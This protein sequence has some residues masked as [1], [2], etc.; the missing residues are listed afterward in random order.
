MSRFLASCCRFFVQGHTSFFRCSSCPSNLRGVLH[1]WRPFATLLTYGVCSVISNRSMFFVQSP[2]RA[3]RDEMRR[4]LLY[5]TL[6]YVVLHAATVATHRCGSSASDPSSGMVSASATLSKV[7]VYGQCCSPTIDRTVC[8]PLAPT[9]IVCGTAGSTR[10][11][12]PPLLLE[13]IADVV[14]HAKTDPLGRG[15][16]ILKPQMQVLLSRRF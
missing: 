3:V 6:R 16:N 1:A 11:F 10:Q 4:D 9:F 14:D 12:S 2:L 15:Y 13:A 7:N 5:L 8:V